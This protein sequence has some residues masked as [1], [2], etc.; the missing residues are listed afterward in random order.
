M[1]LTDLC[2]SLWADVPYAFRALKSA[3]A[4]TVTLVPTLAL[5]LG[6]ATTMLAI[7][8]SV[9][10]RPV[11][12]PRRE[13]SAVLL[14]EVHGTKEYSFSFQQI[15]ALN[16]QSKLLSAVSGYSSMPRPVSTS[17]GSRVALVT[18]VSPNF[19]R[20]LDVQARYGRMLTDADTGAP[21]VV[22]SYAFWRERLHSDLRA[23][24]STVKV[25]GELRT[26][27]GIVSRGIDLLPRLS[28]VSDKWPD[29]QSSV[30]GEQWRVKG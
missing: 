2:S 11:A 27:I 3:P 9:L 26:L 4:Y 13:Q 20:M 23:V 25:V 18:R 29:C 14:R 10:L 19:F 8:N 24:G 17:D 5:G 12:L 30:Q 1:T 21:V 6:A 7:T 15:R 22:V 28:D 16:D